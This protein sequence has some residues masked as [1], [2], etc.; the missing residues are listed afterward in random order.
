MILFQYI[1]DQVI[2]CATV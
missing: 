1:T 2:G